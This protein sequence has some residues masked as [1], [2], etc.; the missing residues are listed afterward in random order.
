MRY[1]PFI[2]ANGSFGIVMWE[3]LSRALPYQHLVHG[4]NVSDA[5]E[6]GERPEVLG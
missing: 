2:E 5:V 3:V 4:W 6:R 1:V